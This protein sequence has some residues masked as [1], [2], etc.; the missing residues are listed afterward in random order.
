MNEALILHAGLPHEVLVIFQLRQ[1]TPTPQLGPLPSLARVVDVKL[2]SV[3]S[4][5]ADGRDWSIVDGRIES[6]KPGGSL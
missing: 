2:T 4:Y 5:A 6:S 1:L 3:P